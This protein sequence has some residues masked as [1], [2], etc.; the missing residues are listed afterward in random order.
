M[1][2]RREQKRYCYRKLPVDMNIHCL[3]PKNRIHQRELPH[4]L[5]KTTPNIILQRLKGK[6]RWQL[7]VR[8]VVPPPA[9]NVPNQRALQKRSE[10]HDN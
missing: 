10:D 3:Y 9:R 5:A 1:L 7:D 8:Q 4:L 2:S 6:L